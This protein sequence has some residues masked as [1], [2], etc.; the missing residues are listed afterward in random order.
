[1]NSDTYTISETIINTDDGHSLYVQDWGNKKAATTFVFLHGGPGSGCDDGHKSFF[2]PHKNRV[3]FFDQR[4]TG[5]STP[6]GSLESNTTADLIGDI[7]QIT[8]AL[9]VKQFVIVGGSWGSTLALAY[10]LKEPSKVLGL[11]LRGIYTG[12]LDEN[13]ALEKGH[14][15]Q[16]F[17]DVWQRFLDKTPTNHHK[18][19]AAYH[20]ERIL[21]SDEDAIKESAYAMNELEVSV[22][23]LDDRMSTEDILEFD[24]IPTKIEIHYTKNL[25][26]MPDKYLLDN[27]YKIK[28]RTFLIQGR[29]DAVCPPITAYELHKKMPNSQ[30][31][32]TLA[33]HSGSDRANYEATKTAI[34][35][36]E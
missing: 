30:L 11:V 21:G 13:N 18:D 31:I 25:C 12:S 35:S 4:G 36:F 26:F 28:T 27:A 20:V 5:K 1:M 22:V 23:K 32:W 34:A 9:D 29:Y 15:R 24:P 3:I 33:G 6:Y 10:T 19:P 17:P 7:S 8:T 2:N 16:F 14:F